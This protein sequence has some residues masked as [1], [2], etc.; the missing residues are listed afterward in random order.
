[1]GT[2][3]YFN[4]VFPI[5][6]CYSSGFSDLNRGPYGGFSFRD[7]LVCAFTIK[8][9]AKSKSTM[10]VKSFFIKKVF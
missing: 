4:S 1:M 10:F 6:I 3:S 8:G 9:K 7:Y 5:K 2:G